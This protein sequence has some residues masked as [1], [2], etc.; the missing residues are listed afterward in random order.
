MVKKVG[1]VKTRKGHAYYVKDGSVY[2]MSMDEMRKKR[3]KGKRKK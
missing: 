3:G 2:E 1:S